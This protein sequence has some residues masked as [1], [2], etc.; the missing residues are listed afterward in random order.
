M[1][2]LQ[3]VVSMSAQTVTTIAHT[4]HIF[5]KP[6]RVDTHLGGTVYALERCGIGLTC[7]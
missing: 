6:P 4:F 5:I 7:Y 1:S 3:S 2:Q